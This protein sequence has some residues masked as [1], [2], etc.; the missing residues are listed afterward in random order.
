[1]WAKLEKAFHIMYVYLFLKAENEVE[2]SVA[3]EQKGDRP[4]WT[5]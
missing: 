5:K 1:M 4:D 3:K 2:C